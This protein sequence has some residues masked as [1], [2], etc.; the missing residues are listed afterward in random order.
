M[1]PCEGTFTVDGIKYLMVILQKEIDG[2]ENK[3]QLAMWKHSNA[4]RQLIS[5]PKHAN[6]VKP[7]FVA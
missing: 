2:S 3:K 4:L 1:S 6:V 5:D 7:V